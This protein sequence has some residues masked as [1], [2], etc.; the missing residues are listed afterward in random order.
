MD[1][2]PLAVWTDA[3]D[4]A[5]AIVQAKLAHLFSRAAL[6]GS[7]S[8][9]TVVQR[10]A[11]GWSGLT[12]RVDGP[13]RPTCAGILRF[14]DQTSF[15]CRARER[16]CLLTACIGTRD[17]RPRRRGLFQ[18]AVRDRGRYEQVASGSWLPSSGY[19]STSA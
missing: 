5:R 6:W 3:R 12:R 17:T 1:A 15:R 11:R 9:S 7:L 18:A 13:R 14:G 10:A 16:P 19:E 2:G 4:E 8:G